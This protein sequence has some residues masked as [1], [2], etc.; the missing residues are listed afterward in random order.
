MRGIET[1]IVLVVVPVSRISFAH[2][3]LVG[4]EIWAST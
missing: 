1:L 2:L 3:G 4:P